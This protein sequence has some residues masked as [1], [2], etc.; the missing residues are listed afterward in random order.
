[1]HFITAPLYASFDELLNLGSVPIESV[2][3]MKAR[4]LPYRPT[5]W[6]WTNSI[7]ANIVNGVKHKAIQFRF[8]LYI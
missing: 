8:L 6:R 2:E 7:Y 5:M 3:T 1:M 4:L